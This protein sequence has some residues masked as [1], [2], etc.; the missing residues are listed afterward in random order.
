[1]TFDQQTRA[2]RIRSSPAKLDE[3][4]AQYIAVLTVLADGVGKKSRE[5]KEIEEEF[6]ASQNRH[7]KYMDS[8]KGELWG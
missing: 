7:R 6:A 3:T 4:S 2:K 5:I 1:M 8:N